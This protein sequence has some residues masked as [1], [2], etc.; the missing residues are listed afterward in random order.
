MLHA[1]KEMGARMSLKMHFLHAHLDFFPENNGDVSDE[2]GKRFHQ[3]IKIIEGRYQGNVS[4]AMMADFRW[5]LQRE[6]DEDHRR[7]RK[8][9]K[10]V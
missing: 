10:H 7:K 1:Y 5:S 6:T 3:E 8:C 4:P 9:P 2:H